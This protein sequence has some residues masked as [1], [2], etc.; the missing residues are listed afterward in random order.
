VLSLIYR[1]HLLVGLLVSPVLLVVSITGAIFAFAP[2]LQ[3]VA[4]E[5]MMHP[6]CE[7]CQRL[8]YQQLFDQVATK[9]PDKKLTAVAVEGRGYS[10]QFSYFDNDGMSLIFVDPYSGA[11]LAHRKSPG[12]AMAP[13]LELHS[14]LFGGLAGRLLVE[15]S[16]GW[17]L[18]TVWLGL[19]LWW[20]SRKKL[21]GGWFPR[22]SKAGR[23]F[24]RD[25]HAVVGFWLIPLCLLFVLTGSFFTMVAG[26]TMLATTFALGG[27]PSA[28]SPGPGVELLADSPRLS[29]DVFIDQHNLQ[30]G[31]DQFFLL[32]PFSPNGNVQVSNDMGRH[33]WLFSKTWFHPQS[34]EVLQ[35]I[36]WSQ[37]DFSSK[38][39]GLMYPL[40]TGKIAGL[41]TQIIAAVGSLL[42]SM[43]SLSGLWI[44]WKRRKA[45]SLSLPEKPSQAKPRWWLVWL[46]PLMLFAP[47]AVASIGVLAIFSVIFSRLKPRDF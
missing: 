20:P 47:L 19:L 29:V 42:I 4:D 6:A 2:Q 33:P 7:L 9:F 31:S 21:G 12:G 38:V 25:I 36:S 11:V 15:L 5:G 37:L 26:K 32:L 44:W 30:S 43:L 23:S 8:P 27:A 35:Q 1:W 10:V 40:H 3:R 14:S 46:L 22:L 13:V 16:T 24:W 41:P 28:L 39:F 18:I 45:G 17:L 34:G